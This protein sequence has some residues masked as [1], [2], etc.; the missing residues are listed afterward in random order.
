MVA[1]QHPLLTLNR[2]EFLLDLLCRVLVS[3][4]AREAQTTPNSSDPS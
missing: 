4:G 3:D 1:Q 2:P